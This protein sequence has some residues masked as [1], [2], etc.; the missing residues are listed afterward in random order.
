MGRSLPRPFALR[1]L[2]ALHKSAGASAI[3]ALRS[4]TDATAR[5]AAF[6]ILVDAE[7]FEGRNAGFLIPRIL[8]ATADTLSGA[9]LRQQA[10]LAQLSPC[11]DSQPARRASPACRDQVHACQ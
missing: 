10:R 2:Q 5:R 9:A 1:P 4:S 3:T 6:A 7:V 11:P 8:S